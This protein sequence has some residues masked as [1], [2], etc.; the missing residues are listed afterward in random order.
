ML[1]VRL[2]AAALL[3]AA[4]V[5]APGQRATA[6]TTMSPPP[7]TLGGKQPSS[8]TASNISQGDTKTPW[9]PS[10]PVPPIDDDAP[11]AAFL[12]AAQKAIAANRTGEAQEALERAESRALDR[13]VKPSKAGEPSRQ[14]L[15][16]Q[17][18]NAR[19]ALGAGDR[20][21]AVALIQG[22]IANPE[23]TEKD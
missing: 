15:V 11:P 5:A 17:I 1:P 13:S 3:A 18:A 20:L 9:A 19:E 10:L 22:A 6:Q 2:F 21:R 14:P 4:V 23:A 7:G 8:S 12:D 16:Q